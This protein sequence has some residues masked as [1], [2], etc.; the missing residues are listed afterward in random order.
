MPIYQAPNFEIDLSR[1]SVFVDTNVLYAAFA[2]TDQRKENAKAFLEVW[3]GDFL[4][5]ASV[6]IETWGMLVGSD[7][8]WLGGFE[9]LDWLRNPGNAAILLPQ[10]INDA[11]SVYQTTKEIHIDCV[12]V[13][14]MRFAHEVT[15]QCNFRPSISIATYDFGDHMRYLNKYQLSFT[16]I[17]PDT[18]D[19]FPDTIF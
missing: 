19:V 3:D 9:F 14:L 5:P 4:I 18:L 15:L 13:F 10:A 1:R 2:R 7:R 16:L 11:E 12:D 17:D 8:Y 6:A